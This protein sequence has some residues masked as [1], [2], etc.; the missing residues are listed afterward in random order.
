M[1]D[2][3]LIDMMSFLEPGLLDNDFI[4]ND[5]NLFKRLFSLS[6]DDNYDGTLISGWRTIIRIF[7]LF[8]TSVIVVTA[9]IAI[10]VKGIKKKKSFKFRKKEAKIAKKIQDFVTT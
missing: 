3:N 6:L 10:L 2:V 8:L 7:T 9:I 5:M 1:N 4:E